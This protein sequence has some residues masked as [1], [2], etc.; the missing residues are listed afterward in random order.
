[1]AALKLERKT[2]ETQRTS[3]ILP[4]AH[5]L[6]ASNVA[7]G[8][9]CPRAAESAG[10][11]KDYGV[12]LA[13]TPRVAAR[14]EELIALRRSQPRDEIVSKS[15]IEAQFV[16]IIRASMT[17][18][19]P[20]YASAGLNLMRLAQLRGYVVNKSAN[21]DAKLDITRLSAAQL[22]AVLE[23][24]VSILTPGDR[25]QVRAIAAG[26]CAQTIPE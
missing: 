14:I 1:M 25:D 22:G 2:R 10:F 18:Q 24:Y 8:M 11:A 12:A 21:V 6:F 26:G 9:S 13:K 20:D 23:D 7:G 15:W 5:E 17:S 4:M 3:E 16:T 19:K